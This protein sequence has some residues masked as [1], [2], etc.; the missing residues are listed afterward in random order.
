MMA[1]VSSNSSSSNAQNNEFEMEERKTAR[2]DVGEKT[3]ELP[4]DEAVV[5]QDP[6]FQGTKS[7][8]D[9]RLAMQ[10]LGKKQQLIVG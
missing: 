7:T 6:D 10:R 8:A 3:N 1:E 4:S 9:D 5:D 2:F